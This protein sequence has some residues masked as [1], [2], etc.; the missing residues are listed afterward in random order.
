MARQKTT[1]SK[2]QILPDSLHGFLARRIIDSLSLGILAA[3]AF[4]LLALF[5]YNRNDPSFNIAAS[6]NHTE[7]IGGLFGANIADI[8][9]Q[10]FGFGALI[11]GL[12]PI[13]WG[14][15]LFK[16]K[17]LR[18]FAAR[19]AF[20]LFATISLSIGLTLFP[21]GGL[22]NQAYLGG[23]SGLLI[24]NKI[25]GLMPDHWASVAHIIIPSLF[26][27]AATFTAGLA[28]ALQ[29]EEW[30]N[31]LHKAQNI[32]INIIYFIIAAVQ[33]IHYWLKKNGAFDEADDFAP[34]K[35]PLWPKMNKPK[36]I[37]PAAKKQPQPRASEPVAKV[38]DHI[39][40]PQNVSRETDSQREDKPKTFKVMTPKKMTKES[41][42]TA[43]ISLALDS[44]TEW[45]LPSIELLAEV[46][47]TETNGQHDT[48]QLEEN[49]E[50]LQNV[51]GDF[52]VKG[53]I[54]SIH[55]GPVV[56]LYELEPAPGTKSSRVIG[57]SDDI[58]RSMSAVSVRA[59]VVPGRNVIGIELPNKIRETVYLRDL[60]QSRDY[61]KSSAHLPLILGNDIGG[62]AV[63]ADLAKMP[64]LLVAGTT[65]SGKS[66]AVNTM[67][68][69]LLF[70]LPPEKCRFIMIDPK[71]L[72]LSVYDDIP[73]LLSPV[74]TEPG[75][76]VVALKWVVQEME[77]RYR[78]MSKLGVRNID[79]YNKRVTEA[80][81]K[82]EVLLRKVQ[83]GFDAE[84]G[85]PT[86]EDQP[87]DLEELPYIVVVVDEFADLMLV[88]GKDVE[89]AIQRLAQ[90]ARAAGIHLI[91][92]T[93]RPSVDVITGVIKA[94]FPTRISFSVTSKIDSRTILGEGGAEQ[95]L[96]QGDMLYMA[97]GGRITRVHGP[98]A[99]DSD[100]EKVVKHIKAQGAPAY[101]DEITE[102]DLDMGFGGDAD[103]EGGSDVDELYDQAV[104]IVARERRASTSFIQR[105]L[106]IGYNRAARIIEEM[107]RQ[108]VVG[109]AN[110]VGKREILVGDH[111]DNY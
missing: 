20:T 7:N 68:L 63:V 56:T 35:K 95:L 91:M 65:G 69:S 54:V 107:E 13:I 64:H 29:K 45:E 3:G 52:N 110:H 60:L 44:D 55:P 43:Q 73:H 86:Y 75:K 17:P 111:G 79:G 4:L 15:R 26:L 18:N 89:N 108:G 38:N 88:A 36:A 105:H 24:T 101:L 22:I 1:K 87:L 62:H 53:D 80:A 67:I 57:L 50:S 42:S 104:A 39:D 40:P 92:A 77:N 48:K 25:T 47:K 37:K 72:E 58:A 41:S 82:G 98:F 61:V 76:A 99:T 81:K 14:L 23:S 70:R 96:G 94:N 5:T 84:T 102:A 106:Q 10:S 30:L 49:A 8:L 11:L 51:L 78:A 103:G 74:V 32:A 12:L 83:T 33:N 34:T 16:R 97:A 2:K 6:G 19:I 85:K 21:A 71:M 100:V 93:Q 46:P 28:T 109:P 66:V 59:A 31:I 90:M 27:M 9:L